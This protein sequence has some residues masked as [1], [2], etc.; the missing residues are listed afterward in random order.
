MRHSHE[1]GDWKIQ[2]LQVNGNGQPIPFTPDLRMKEQQPI[3]E[4]CCDAKPGVGVTVAHE[5]LGVL[6]RQSPSFQFK[7]KASFQ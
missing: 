4:V 3:R 6:A 2:R 5:D 7:A 1:M